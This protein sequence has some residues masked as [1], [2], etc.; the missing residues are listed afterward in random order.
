MV[1]VA[2]A[3]QVKKSTTIG[4]YDSLQIIIWAE[5]NLLKYYYFFNKKSFT[6]HN[7]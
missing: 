1:D 2:T 3:T 5:I 4:P 6:V 7:P